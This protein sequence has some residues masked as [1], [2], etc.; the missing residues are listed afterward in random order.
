M[1]KLLISLLLTCSLCQTVFADPETG[2]WWNADESGRGFS[3]EQQADKIFFAAYL[4]DDSGSPTWFT[5]LLEEVA[6]NRY[7]GNLQ[8]FSGGQTLLGA[9]QAPTVL[10]DNAGQITLDF[11]ESNN[12][13]L[14]W[15][16]G[17]VAITRFIFAQDN[18]TPNNTAAVQRGTDL[19]QANCSNSTCHTPDP[20]INQNNILSGS[21]PNAIRSAFGRVQRM[22]DAGVPD[23]VSDSEIEDIAAYLESVKP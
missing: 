2:W 17:T 21:N 6:D 15:P 12:G 23:R 14:T 4:Y 19:F 8:Q 20:T 5:A 7:I 10:N 13:T 11:P 22:I 1:K 9:F 18:S 16:G 3:I